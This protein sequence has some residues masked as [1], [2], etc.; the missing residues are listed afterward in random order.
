MVKMGKIL[1]FAVLTQKFR[2]CHSHNKNIWISTSINKQ[3][4]IMKYLIVYACAILALFSSVASASTID[5]KKS[6]RSEIMSELTAT[7]PVSIFLSFFD[8]RGV[9]YGSICIYIYSYICPFPR[10][11]SFY[12]CWFIIF[13][14]FQICLLNWYVQQ[15]NIIQY[16]YLFT[17]H[18]CIF[19]CI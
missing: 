18:I 6:L 12:H 5:N 15:N 11:S 1:I 19:I 4:E 17:H 8:R 9:S 2:N 16:L 13:L 7:C 14:L 10:C 3:L